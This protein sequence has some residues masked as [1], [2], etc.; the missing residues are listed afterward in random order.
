MLAVLLLVLAAGGGG[1]FA[2]WRLR[3][4]S[5]VPVVTPP[6]AAPSVPAPS[7]PAPAPVVLPPPPQEA[8]HPVAPPANPP[9]TEAAAA[10]SESSDPSASAPV[11]PVH[12]VRP[13]LRKDDVTPVFVRSQVKLRGCLTHHR[14][15]LPGKQGQLLLSFTVA[16]SGEVREAHL[17]GALVHSALERCIVDEVKRMRFPRHTG[18]DDSFDQP[19][20][21]DFKD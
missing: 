12:R 14:A 2:G 6:P 3:H 10:P 15:L 19:F 7:L 8:A 4:R 21:Y 9:H 16:R 5:P 1:V 13:H 17:G 20:K 11:R 18:A